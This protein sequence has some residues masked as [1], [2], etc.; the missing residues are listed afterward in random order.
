MYNIFHS[1]GSP[2]RPTPS[3]PARGGYCEGAPIGAGAAVCQESRR[4]SRS[5]A[6]VVS[7]PAS[8]GSS[9]T[10]STKCCTEPATAGDARA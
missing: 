3:G 7:H 8:V 9:R 5:R 6:A 10:A 1:V 4:L 2:G